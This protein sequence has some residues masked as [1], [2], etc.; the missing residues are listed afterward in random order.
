MH[1]TRMPEPCEI[2]QGDLVGLLVAMLRLSRLPRVRL[3]RAQRSFCTVTEAVVKPDAA[4]SAAGRPD[5]EMVEARIL[6]SPV[7]PAS[8]GRWDPV[9]V[10]LLCIFTHETYADTCADRTSFSGFRFSYIL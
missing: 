8:I 7:L 9:R 1:E 5:P 2:W 3:A 6:F 10:P 4:S